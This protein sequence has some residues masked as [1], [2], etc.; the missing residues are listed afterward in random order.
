MNNENNPHVGIVEVGTQGTDNTQI[1]CMHFPKKSVI[2]S[3]KLMD[4]AGVVASDVNFVEVALKNQ[5]G[6]VIVAELDSRA[7]HEN[8]LGAKQAK[9]MNLVGADAGVGGVVVP[10]GTNLY[11]DYQ[12][13]GTVTLTLAK[14]FIEYYPL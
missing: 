12:E 2:K 3:V 1:G 4:N 11:F 10:A 13:S 5:A 7:A 8:G 6:D 9:A 14:L